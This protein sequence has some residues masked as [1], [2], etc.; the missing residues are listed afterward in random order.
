LASG[1]ASLASAINSKA[2]LMLGSEAWFVATII[3]GGADPVCSQSSE[4]QGVDYLS[5][6]GILDPFL[7][8]SISICEDS[9]ASA[10]D[11]IE[12]FVETQTVNTYSVT[13]GE[14]ESILSV[15]LLR[16]GQETPLDPVTEVNIYGGR[17]RILSAVTLLPR[18]QLNLTI[19]H[20]G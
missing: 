13:L 11:P 7:S 4:S 9:Y 18:D 16:G 15:S 5:F 8:S 1:A 10:L 2:D 3:D 12:R 19:S 20:P 6:L 17:V 14:G